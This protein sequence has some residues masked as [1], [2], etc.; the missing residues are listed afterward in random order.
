[1]H[2]SSPRLYDCERVREVVTAGHR[3]LLECE[4]TAVLMATATIAEA[5]LLRP[6]SEEWADPITYMKRV[7]P[8]VEQ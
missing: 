6:S 3:G 1:M 5:P 7:Q 2:L 4:V 8:I